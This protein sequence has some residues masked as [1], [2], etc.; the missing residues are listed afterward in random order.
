M[1]MMLQDALTK[2]TPAQLVHQPQEITNETTS[3]P[4]ENEDPD[5]GFTVVGKRKR[6][7]ITPPQPSQLSKAVDKARHAAATKPAAKPTTQPIQQRAKA[8]SQPST[9][10]N[11]VRSASTKPLTKTATQP[12]PKPAAVKT[13]QPIQ[14]SCHPQ[15]GRQKGGQQSKTRSEGIH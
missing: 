10:R 1:R 5:D 3:Q 4:L 6:G 12:T 7:P 11:A 15:L 9:S 13:T 8:N 2:P 14:S